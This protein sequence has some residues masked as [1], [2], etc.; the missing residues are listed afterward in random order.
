LFLRVIPGPSSKKGK[1]GM[2]REDGERED[3]ERKGREGSR[4]KLSEGK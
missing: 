1:E 4:V 2:E 3:R